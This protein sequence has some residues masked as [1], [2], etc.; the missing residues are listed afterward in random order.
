MIALEGS[1]GTAK[2]LADN[3]CKYGFLD[4]KNSNLWGSGG[5]YFFKDSL[6]GVDHAVKWHQKKLEKNGL[7]RL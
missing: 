6:S 3:I 2:T 5:V 4:N 1:H 7:C